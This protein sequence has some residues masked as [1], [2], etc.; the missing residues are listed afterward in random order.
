MAKANPVLEDLARIRR[1]VQIL[2]QMK[3]H[4]GI[5]GN[6]GSD[7]LMIANVHEFGATIKMT[8]KMRRYLGAMGL[9]DGDGNYTPPAGHQTG[10]IN[11]PERSFIRASYDTGKQKMD[12]IVREA[13]D[14]MVTGERDAAGTMNAIG[15]QLAQM[16]QNYINEGN[17]KP[18]K[19]EFTQSRSSQHTPLVDSGRLVGSITWEVEGG[20]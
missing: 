20:G 16:T 12:R 17:A 6:A 9:F 13:L 2:A 15:A 19:S 5:Q 1:E 7:L 11:I 14:K 10:Y 18:P 4:V 3:I 8:D